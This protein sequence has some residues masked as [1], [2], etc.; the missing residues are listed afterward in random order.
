MSAMGLVTV[1]VELN[2]GRNRR[3]VETLA[4]GGAVYVAAM[5]APA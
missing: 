2:R 5:T 4:D 3:D 1:T